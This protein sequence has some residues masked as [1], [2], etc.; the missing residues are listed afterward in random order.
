MPGSEPI[1]E[2]VLD[3]LDTW[4]GDPQAFS[5]CLEECGAGL[6]EDEEE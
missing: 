2:C 5:D 6:N 3:C 4:G 1:D